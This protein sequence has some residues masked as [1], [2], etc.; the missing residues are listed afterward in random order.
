MPGLQRIR[1]GGHDAEAVR[2]VVRT[3]THRATLPAARGVK[4]V[5]ITTFISATLR[6]NIP[7]SPRRRPGFR[8]GVKSR[9]ALSRGRQ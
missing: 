1:L 5:G 8:G 7:F 3:Q 2:S 4:R 9:E 6:E